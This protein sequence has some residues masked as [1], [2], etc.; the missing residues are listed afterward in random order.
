MNWPSIY[1]YQGSWWHGGF[2]Q[3]GN[4]GGWRN[5]LHEFGWLLRHGKVHS[6]WQWPQLI[7]GIGRTWYDGPIWFAHLGIFSVDLSVQ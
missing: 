5:M 2:D 1:R 6:C 4:N 3:Q 7:F